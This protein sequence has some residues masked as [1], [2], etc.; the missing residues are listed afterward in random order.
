VLGAL[1]AIIEGIQRLVETALLLILVAILN[2]DQP[3][4]AFKSACQ[5]ATF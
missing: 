4:P 5:R 3:Q 2:H 1:I